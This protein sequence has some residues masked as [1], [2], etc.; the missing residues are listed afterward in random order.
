MNTVQVWAPLANKVEVEIN[1]QR[2]PME[3]I[4]D[5]WWACE[6]PLAECGNDYAFI[7]NG[8]KPLPD[9][10][11]PWQPYGVSGPSRFVNHEIYP[12]KYAGWQP[13]PLSSAVIYEL[14]VGTFSPEGSFE[15]VINRLDYLA[16]LG[17]T[18]IEL[19]PVAQ[20]PGNRGWGYDGV[21]LYAPHQAYGGPDG[22]KYLVDSCHGHNIAVLLDV[23][24]NHLGPEGN[25]LESFAPYFTDRYTTPWGKAINFD[26]P[27]SDEV[28]RFFC[29]NAV[30][31]L[32]DYHID[33]LRI[34]AIHAIY[35]SSAIHILEQL[36]L[37]VDALQAVL[38][39]H[40]TLIAESDL[41]NPRIIQSREI[42][43]Y[44]VEAQWNDDFHHTLHVALTG[45][46]SGYYIDFN[47]L[48]D[49]AKAM[50]KVFV[51]DGKYSGFRRRCHGR[52]V[53]G[54]SGHKF[55]S[56]IQTHD[57]VGNRAQGKRLGHLTTHGKQ[58][59][60]A[61]LVLT[62]PYIPMVFQGEEW[63]ASSPFQ[64]FTDYQNKELGE[65]VRRGRL[66][67]FAVFGWKEQDIPAPQRKETFEHSKLDWQ[68]KDQGTHLATLEWYKQL[69]GLRKQF[70]A[71]TD[72]DLNEV[73]PSYDEKNGWFLV[74]R[75]NVLIACNLSDRGQ[76]IPLEK[77]FKLA[78]LLAS[79]DGVK[80]EQGRM[81]L[82][83]ETVAISELL[84]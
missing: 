48:G 1:R 9:P 29:D 3:K 45:E 44:G 43:G 36:A 13:P 17:I 33:G 84:N 78:L 26:G 8:R 54:I 60:A 83:P 63:D 30:M 15:G 65:A 5:G 67:E 73:K 41:N 53:E 76:W 31:W 22:L 57:Q 27:E 16:N 55:L 34:D 11:S 64:F 14:H 40:L 24:N 18:H 32:R 7:L 70:S 61:A 21:N 20:F 77:T 49:L 69:I 58:K 50:K 10:R 74:K 38:G 51:I 71:L 80:I 46:Q 59:I 39:K 35:D 52:A 19:M 82:M 47:S 62:S 23:V 56:Y 42:G 6:T 37:Q 25:F 68:E 2:L 28:R 79:E 4:K 75:R 12:W 66:Q 81:F 72:G